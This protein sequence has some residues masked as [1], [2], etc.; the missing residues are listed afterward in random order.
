MKPTRA[1]ASVPVNAPPPGAFRAFGKWLPT[2]ILCLSCWGC[3]GDPPTAPRTDSP[4]PAPSATPLP[5]GSP[6]ASP[7]ATA[8]GTEP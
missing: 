7:T 8:T 2:V 6:T 3:F 4:T 5:A 1:P